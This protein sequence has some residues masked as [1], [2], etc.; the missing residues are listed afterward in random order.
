MPP[1]GHFLWVPQSMDPGLKIPA[2]YELR[3]TEGV[4]KEAEPNSQ[5]PFFPF[6]AS[7]T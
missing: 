6:A 2:P 7:Q 4:E 5:T 3:P 1:I